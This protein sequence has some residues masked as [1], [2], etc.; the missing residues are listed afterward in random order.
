MFQSLERIQNE[1]K[2]T[3]GPKTA[4]LCVSSLVG[5]CSPPSMKVRGQIESQEVIVLIESI[6]SHNFITKNL[7][8]KL[9]LRCTPTQ[10]FGV[11][12]GN[13]DETITSEV[14]QGLYLEL[15]EMKVI[16][17]F[18]PFEIGYILHHFGI[19]MACYFR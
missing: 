5:F 15:A 12:M 8:S 16:A 4:T 14:C 2:I 6:A 18:F 10:E 3:Y 1:E 9:H 11:Q 19:S 17:D 7:V 13:G